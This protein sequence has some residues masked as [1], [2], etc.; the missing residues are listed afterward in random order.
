MK[1]VLRGG[2]RPAMN[3]FTVIGAGNG[4]KAT[5]ADLALQG[6]GVRLFEFPE[7]AANIEELSRQPW[8]AATG[9][10]HGRAPLQCVTSDLAEAVAGT[11]A[12][13]VVTQAAAHQRVARELAPLVR[14]DQLVLLNPGSTGG[15][16]EFA[17]VFRE[18]GIRELPLLGETGTLTYGCRGAG[19]NVNV[20]L[21]V[22][23]VV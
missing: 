18:Q 11:D 21:K 3:T 12:I 9:D 16:L 22:R 8:L 14:P 15:S 10:V 4:G 13:V 5:A 1:P 2:P 20:Y 19:A 6:K 17:R 23:R 7:F